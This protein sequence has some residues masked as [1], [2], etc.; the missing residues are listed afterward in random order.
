MEE[1][2]S[3]Y[4]VS[5]LIQRKRPCWSEPSNFFLQDTEHRSE[6]NFFTPPL[7]GS[8]G[9]NQT[10]KCTDEVR[11]FLERSPLLPKAN[12]GVVNMQTV[13]LQGS[14]DSKAEK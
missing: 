14:S 8:G 3:S 4:C 1:E 11:V 13:S 10:D 7:A 6:Q 5:F 2:I 12:P 9:E